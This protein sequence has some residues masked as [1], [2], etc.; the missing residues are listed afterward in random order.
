MEKTIE[1]R[2]QEIL[3]AREQRRAENLITNKMK[4]IK[5]WFYKNDYIEGQ[6]S[7]GIITKDDKKYT[8]YLAEYTQKLAEY[9]TLRTQLG[10]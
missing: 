4:S 9:R 3:A 5:N 8:D 1:Q 10:E 2:K 6:V 7:K